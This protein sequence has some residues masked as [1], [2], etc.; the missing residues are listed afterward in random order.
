VKRLLHAQG[1][2]AVDAAGVQASIWTAAERL[3]E[4]A[5]LEGILR[6]RLGPLAAHRLRSM[7]APLPPPLLAEERAAALAMKLAI[8]LLQRIRDTCDGRLLL[9]KGPEVVR[10]YPAEARRFV[11]V[12]VLADDARAAHRALVAS[13]FVEVADEEGYL[14]HHHEVPLKWPTI[15]LQVE[16][17]ESLR[18]PS[19]A[20]GLASAEMFAAAGPS[21]VG[22]DGLE[23][24]HP[25]HHALALASHAWLD[26]PLYTLRDLLDI[27]ALS[28]GVDDD[29]LT[30]AAS[31]I[32]VGRL[33]HTTRGAIDAL[34][35]DGDQTFPLRTWARHL[36]P[37]R[38]RTV[39]ESHLQRWLRSF[40]ERPFHAALGESVH[41][42]REEIVP[43]EGDSWRAKLSR[44]VSAIRRPGSQ[45]QRDTAASKQ[46]GPPES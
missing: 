3:L 17:H 21:A 36:A 30:R 45:V 19:Y 2:H 13:G 29:E 25:V 15:W 38:D 23:T 22:I 41:V 40:S 43:E 20:R 24:L 5:E 37:V 46:P 34:F 12:D 44:M 14:E 6:H 33:W 39:F 1:T 4:G 7:G 9:F 10:R 16:V 31:D 32:G 27:A 8:P 11:D 28:A 18:W 26:E 35:G 42:L